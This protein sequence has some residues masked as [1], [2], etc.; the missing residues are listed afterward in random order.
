MTGEHP[1]YVEG[2]GFVPA[3]QIESGD[4]VRTPEGALVRVGR[5][6]WA[7]RTA[8]VYN[9]EVAGFHTYFVG[10]A[11]VWVHNKKKADDAKCFTAGTPVGTTRGLQA[12]EKIEVGD[13][14]PQFEGA[15]CSVQPF[16]QDSEN[17]A[18][19]S[20]EFDSPYG[21]DDTLSVELMRSRDWLERHDVEIG[22]T[23]E[24]RFEELGVDAPG[25]V[26]SL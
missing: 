10:E 8:T 20:L 1:V 5:S 9:L 7:Q 14:V 22:G 19:V 6:T 11:R 25:R 26:R 3:R 2:A 17:C 13:R 16:A 23:V 4:R 12:I 18:M 21:Y 15:S 24:L